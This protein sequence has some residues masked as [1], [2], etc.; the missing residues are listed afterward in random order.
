MAEKTWKIGEYARGG[1]IT[2][3]ATKTKVTVTGKE[4][5]YAA[6]TSRGASQ[7]NA[8]AFTVMTLP[9][10]APNARRRIED[11]LLGLTTSYYADQIMEWIESKTEFKEA[12]W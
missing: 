7:A 6:G 1:V 2:A 5:D 11:F 10:N 12:Y 3:K 8:K 9:T 4:W